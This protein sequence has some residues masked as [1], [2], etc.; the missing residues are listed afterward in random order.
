M[1]YIGE[2]DLEYVVCEYGSGSICVALANLQRAGQ[3]S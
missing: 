3:M 1:N 2:A